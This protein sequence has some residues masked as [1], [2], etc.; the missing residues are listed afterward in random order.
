MIIDTDEYI[1]AVTAAQMLG[2]SRATMSYH[3][4]V[5]SFQGTVQV[6]HYWLL[7]RKAVENYVRKKPGPKPKGVEDIR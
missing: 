5:G 6:G 3:C 7:L 4:K 2:I 1:D